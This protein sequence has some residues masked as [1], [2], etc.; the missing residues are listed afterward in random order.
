MQGR[1]AAQA[2]PHQL[3]HFNLST[4]LVVQNFVIRSTIFNIWFQSGIS[5]IALV[6]V[7]PLIPKMFINFEPLLKIIR[8]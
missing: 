5:L 2:A 3:T 6:G 4:R 7:G 8:S 1:L